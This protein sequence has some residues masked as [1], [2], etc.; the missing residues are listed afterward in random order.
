MF[1]GLVSQAAVATLQVDCRDELLTGNG[2]VLT[3]DDGKTLLTTGRQQCQLTGP[4]GL[5]LPLPA[6]AQAIM[7]GARIFS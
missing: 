6:W 1:L 4:G 2:A 5:R 7:S 3:A